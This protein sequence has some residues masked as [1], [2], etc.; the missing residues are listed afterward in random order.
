MA[1]NAQPGTPTKSDKPTEIK[2]DPPETVRGIAK[3]L[4]D[5]GF[6][7]WWLGGCVP[8]A[9]LGHPHLDWDLATAATPPEV[10]KLFKRTVPV[11]VEF[12]TIGV[13]DHNNVMHEVTT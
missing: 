11:G 9:L 13:I 10:R 8:Y 2:L 1:V 4:E 7:T 5:A 12:G 3:R 6:E